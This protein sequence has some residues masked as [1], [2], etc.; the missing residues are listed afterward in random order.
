MA[1]ALQYPQLWALPGKARSPGCKLRADPYD[2]ERGG[3]R[4]LLTQ[5]LAPYPTSTQGLLDSRA[6]MVSPCHV[7]GKGHFLFSLLL[8][9][10][11]SGWAKWRPVT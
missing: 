11:P 6:E 7:K 8:L 4:V 5:V 1:L 3:H 2:Q 9:K 10:G